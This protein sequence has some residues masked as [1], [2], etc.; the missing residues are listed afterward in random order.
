[1]PT[2][3]GNGV[4][5]SIM[6]ASNGNGAVVHADAAEKNADSLES[7]GSSVN[8]RKCDIVYGIEDNPP[9]YMCILLGL[10]VGEID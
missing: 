9:W 2:P 1:M 6:D 4:T 10:Q 7:A 5:V 8:L 3:A